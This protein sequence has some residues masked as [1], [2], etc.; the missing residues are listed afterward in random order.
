MRQFA[1]VGICRESSAPSSSSIAPVSRQEHKSTHVFQTTA[2]Q[3]ACAE[4]QTELAT[5]S[6]GPHPNIDSMSV[7]DFSQPGGNASP[8]SESPSHR[9]QDKIVK[10][11]WTKEDDIKVG[12]LVIQYERTL[13]SALQSGIV[14]MA[15][16]GTARRAGQ[17]WLPTCPAAL[18]SKS[19]SDG[20]TRRAAAHLVL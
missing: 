10:C 5:R 16:T 6:R 7:S 9:K 19:G 3:P 18:A 14:L 15:G 1:G 11:P 2:G 8:C 12:E 20:T 4:T 13:S 17:R